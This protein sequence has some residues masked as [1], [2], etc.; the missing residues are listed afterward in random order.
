VC[1][2]GRG[3][4]EGP[5]G[6]SVVLGG[7]TLPYLLHAPALPAMRVLAAA[8]AARNPHR[9]LVADVLAPL[10]SAQHPLD[11]VEWYRGAFEFHHAVYQL[12]DNRVLNLVTQSVAHIV[13]DH[14][15]STVDVV[16]IRPDIACA[17]SPSAPPSWRAGTPMPAS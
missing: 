11:G 15:L 8:A 7:V 5:Y 13:A 1:G 14:V 3:V 17:T 10:L 4:E 9:D 12:C 2:T 6:P 16:P